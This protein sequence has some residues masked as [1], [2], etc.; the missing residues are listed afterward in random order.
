MYPQ[1]L[2][3]ASPPEYVM[4]KWIGS[5][6]AALVLTAFAAAAEPRTVNYGEVP[7]EERKVV[8][9]LQLYAAAQR[10]FAAKEQGSIPGNTLGGKESQYCDNFRN[11]YYGKS[12]MGMSIGK[13][14][15]LRLIEKSMA[16]AFAG[17]TAGAPAPKSAVNAAVAEFGYLFLEDPG[18]KDWAGEFGLVAYPAKYIESGRNIYCIWESGDSGAEK[19]LGVFALDMRKRTA[20][21]AKK[22]ETPPL[23]GEDESPRNAPELWREVV[24][25]WEIR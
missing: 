2:K 4:K 6:L 3:Q 12:T 1:A 20:G 14:K 19:G 24:K 23:L 15:S 21:R 17:D 18:V 9:A 10:T 7:K 22:G 13:V 5:I 16:D 11:L 25:S 8:A